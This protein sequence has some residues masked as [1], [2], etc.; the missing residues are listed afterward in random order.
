[1]SRVSFTEHPASVGETYLMHL[2]QAWSFGG[3]MLA[4]SLALFVHAVLPFLFVRTGSTIIAALHDRM[5][6]HRVRPGA[7]E[8]F[9]VTKAR[10]PGGSRHAA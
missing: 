2:R 7:L 5:V 6:V 3:K 8:A 10:R 4:G 1:M 9:A